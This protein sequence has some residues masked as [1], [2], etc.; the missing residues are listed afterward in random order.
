MAQI[1]VYMTAP[2]EA[3]AQRIGRAL[4][5]RRLA[6]CVNI[7]PP[8]RSM[9]WWD[10]AVQSE[11]ETAFLAKTTAELYE[12]LQACVLEMHPYEIPC[13]V[14]LSIDRGHEPFL[15]WIDAQT[16]IAAEPMK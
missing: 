7:L 11:S 2:D 13:I 3:V 1:L 12:S 10:G 8:V 5:D 4:V 6:A 14:A 9:Y 15:R 16:G